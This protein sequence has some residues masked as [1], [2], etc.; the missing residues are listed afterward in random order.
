MSS[1][2][3]GLFLLSC[4]F[5][6]RAC[7]PDHSAPALWSLSASAAL[8]AFIVEPRAFSE[9]TLWAAAGVCVWVLD[10][11]DTKTDLLFAGIAGFLIGASAPYL[12]LFV[13]EHVPSPTAIAAASVMF[14]ALVA[15]FALARFSGGAMALVA[16]ALPLGIFG[17]VALGAGTVLAGAAAVMLGR[18]QAPISA[19]ALLVLPALGFIGGVE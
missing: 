2:T 13:D 4:A 19:T 3:I 5:L 14:F 18:A 15:G 1:L 11:S 7:A 10:R 16:S 9:V 17:S 12:A 6:S 8:V